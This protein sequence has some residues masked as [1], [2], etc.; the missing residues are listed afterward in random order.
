MA[1]HLMFVYGTLKRDQP[2]H[3]VLKDSNNGVADCVGTGY[4]IDK[5]PLV[6]ATKYNITQL[7]YKKFIGHQIFGEIYAVDDRMLSR[8]NE[9]ECHPK[10]YR[11]MTIEIEMD[12]MS[13]K[14]MST[15]F[16]TDFKPQLLELEMYNTY[17][18]FGSHG[19]RYTNGVERDNS[20]EAINRLVNEIKI[21]LK[22]F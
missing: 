2:N 1:K 7:L 8:M 12:D 15:Y 19:L 4:T 11:R 13:R 5:W 21:M 14:S 18:T 20:D 22:V 9:L 16:L 10:F 6:I 17:D 3:Y